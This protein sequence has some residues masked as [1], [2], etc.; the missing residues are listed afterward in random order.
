MLPD[1]TVIVTDDCAVKLPLSRTVAVIVW[2][3]GESVTERVLPDPSEPSRLEIHAIDEPMLP[4]SGSVAEAASEI[5]VPDGNEPPVVGAEIE[6]VG[7]VFVGV[8]PMAP[9]P[10]SIANDVREP[11]ELDRVRR[12]VV[13]HL[14]RVLASCGSLGLCSLIR[15]SNGIDAGIPGAIPRRVIRAAVAAGVEA[16]RRADVGLDQLVTNAFCA[17]F[18]KSFISQM[19]FSEPW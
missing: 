13:A 18:V 5:D 4:S 11:R 19:S 7:A 17:A 12:V 1:V 6:T 9:P 16:P 15:D 10:S 14:E 3:P 8:P 2:L